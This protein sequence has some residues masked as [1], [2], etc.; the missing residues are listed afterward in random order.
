MQRPLDMSHQFLDAILDTNSILVDAT[1]GNGND[2]LYFA[3]K[4]KRLYAFDVQEK[5]L[6]VTR[7]KL[8]KAQLENVQLIQDGHEKVD[9]YLDQVDAAIFN[10][11]YLPNADKSI[12][13]R[14]ETTIEAL[15]KLLRALRV[16]GRIAIMV[17]YGHEGGLKEKDALLDYLSQLPQEKVTVMSYQALNQKNCPPFLLMLEKL[18]D[19]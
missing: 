4:V 8:Q 11:G 12:I 14:A 10:L 3:P 1:M 2:T 17:Y 19:D 5:A 13:T 9:D 6:Q 15:K 16:G 18:A 7:E